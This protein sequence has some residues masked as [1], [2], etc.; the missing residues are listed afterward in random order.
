M[1]DS[2]GPRHDLATRRLA[3]ALRLFVGAGRR[4]SVEALAE[5]TAIPARTVRSYVAGDA[6][7]SLAN[8]L[9]M[10]RHLPEAWV[11]MLLDAAG[12]GG[13]HRLEAGAGDTAHGIRT[14]VGLAEGVS[15]LGRAL[16]D[17]KLDH[18]ERRILAPALRQ[19]ASDLSNFAASIDGGAK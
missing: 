7:P 13:A 9:E 11:N 6:T 16:E 2:H 10:A 4:Y 12:L 3:D 17:Q 18:V 14:L 8:L 5:A 1:T 15:Q 19:L